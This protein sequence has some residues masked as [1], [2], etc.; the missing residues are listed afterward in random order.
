M[1]IIYIFSSINLESYTEFQIAN[2]VADNPS[3]LNLANTLYE[4]KNVAAGSSNNKA[5]FQ[6]E[7]VNT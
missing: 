2:F 4:S 5:V 6:S 7:M 1:L 3:I